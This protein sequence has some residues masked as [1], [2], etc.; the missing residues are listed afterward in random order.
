MSYMKRGTGF[1]EWVKGDLLGDI[2]GITSR[3]MFGGYGFYLRGK[4][5]GI[6]ADGKLYFKADARSI[7]AFEEYGSKPF[8]YTHKNKKVVAMSYWEVPEEVMEDYALLKQW[9]HTAAA[10]SKK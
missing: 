8:R 1:Y 10:C 7:P 5:F 3:S 4:I 2:P 6:I 9:V